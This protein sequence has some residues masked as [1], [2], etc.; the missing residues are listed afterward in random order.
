MKD[1]AKRNKVALTITSELV[2]LD[3]SPKCEAYSMIYDQCIEAWDVLT[4][5]EIK[6]MVQEWADYLPNQYFQE[7]K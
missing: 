2:Q 5:K 4:L 7:I 6:A 1:L 3:I